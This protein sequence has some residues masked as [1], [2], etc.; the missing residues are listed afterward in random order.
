MLAA[1]KGAGAK[2]A[3]PKGLGFFSIVRG[4]E[5]FASFSL[6]FFFSGRVIRTV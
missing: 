1:V 2:G 4:F 6:I 5:G 3:M